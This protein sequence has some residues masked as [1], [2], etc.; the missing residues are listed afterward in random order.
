MEESFKNIHLEMIRQF[1]IQSNQ[2]T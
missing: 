2:M 1:Q